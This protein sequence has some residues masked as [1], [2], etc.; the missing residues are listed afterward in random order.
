MPPFIYRMRP[1]WYKKC[2]IISSFGSIFINILFDRSS[3]ISDNRI[4][5]YNDSFYKRIKKCWESCLSAHIASTRAQIGYNAK[6]SAVYEVPFSSNVRTQMVSNV[7]QCIALIRGLNL[8]CSSSQYDM[9]MVVSVIYSLYLK[10][11]FQN[12]TK[13]VLPTYLYLYVG[14]YH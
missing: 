12:I 4:D 7:M 2:S 11:E 13:T 14:I 6:I 1:G 3:F 5:W 8:L 9:D 10:D